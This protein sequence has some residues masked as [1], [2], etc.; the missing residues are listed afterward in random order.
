MAFIICWFLEPDKHTRATV[1]WSAGLATFFIVAISA[2][3]PI[4]SLARYVPQAYLVPI[5]PLLA[6]LMLKRPLPTIFACIMAGL[7]LFNH[8]LIGQ[9]YVS[10]NIQTSAAI[11]SGLVDLA[12]R[13]QNRPLLIHFNEFRSNRIMFA[14]AGLNY[15]VIPE[16]SKCIGARN[17]LPENTTKLCDQTPSTHK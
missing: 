13:S 14:D 9:S 5:V 3:N 10:Y 17:I 4:S 2:I 12:A 7:L 15:V 16:A 6:L 11:R 8:F 1:L